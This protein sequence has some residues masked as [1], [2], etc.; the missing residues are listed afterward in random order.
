MNPD[1]TPNPAVLGVAGVPF[2]GHGTNFF[3]IPAG[4]RIKRAYGTITLKTPGI[5][6][7][8]RICA[9]MGEDFDSILQEHEITKML[10]TDPSS[11]IDIDHDN[12][13]VNAHLTGDG[14][15]AAWAE[16][17]AINSSGVYTGSGGAFEV[18]LKFEVV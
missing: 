10:S 4:K 1:G 2:D 13:P 6:L 16:I 5:E 15:K 12:F 8:L 11:R 18:Q 14:Y 3:M 7:L 9:G 17:Q